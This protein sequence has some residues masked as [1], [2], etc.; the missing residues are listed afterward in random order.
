MRGAESGKWFEAQSG[1]GLSGGREDAITVENTERKDGV[2]DPW[3]RLTCLSVG[4]RS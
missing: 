1:R 4:F 3:I 2:C